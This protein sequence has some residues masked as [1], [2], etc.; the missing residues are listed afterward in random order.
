[1]SDSTE[2]PWLPKIFLRFERAYDTS[3]G[4]ARIV[5]DAG[6]AYIK[7]MGN[8]QGP[9]PLAC[10]WIGTYLARWFGLPTFAF[11]IVTLDAEDTIPFSRGGTAEPGPAFVS[12]AVQGHPWGGDAEELE[13]LDNKGM[14][15]WLVV[16]DTWSRNCDRYPPD[17]SIR[18][19]NYDN[20]FLSE[21]GQDNRLRI[22]AMDH[23][24]CLTCGRDLN[25]RMSHIDQVR[26]ERLYGLF[27]EFIPFLR[28]EEIEKALEKLKMVD[29]ELI[30][31]SL[32][33]IPEEW[34]VTQTART[35]VVE[36]LV[37]RASFVADTFIEKLEDHLERHVDGQ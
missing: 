22:I 30:L 7:A 15:S 23:S 6:P 14:I 19:P 29:R 26:D 12:K 27:P 25:A 36:L 10:E 1:M 24:H 21:E 32:E 28:Q 2:S 34:E 9:H 17:L 35:A 37:R 20:V 13:Q 4:T 16:F 5:T 31:D 3:M 11:A 33:A 18:R 8:R